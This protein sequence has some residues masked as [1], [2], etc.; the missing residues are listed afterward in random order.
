MHGPRFAFAFTLLLC[1]AAPP[2][3]HVLAAQDGAQGSSAGGGH[4]TIT[5]SDGTIIEIQFAYSAILHGDGR[6]SGALHHKGLFQGQMID[7]TGDVT[8]VAIDSANRRAWI[9]GVITANRSQHPTY[10]DSD[11]AQPGHDIW[12][13]VLDVEDGGS[14]LPDRTTFVG[15]EGV[16]PSSLAYCTTRPWRDDNIWPVVGNLSVR[17]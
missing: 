7:F 16:I 6:A 1:L 4:Y 9:G 8:C 15:F 11:W 14:G 12:F 3:G 5:L 13:R 10:R 2:A 17:P